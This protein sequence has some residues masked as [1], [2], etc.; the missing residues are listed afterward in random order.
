MFGYCYNGG[1][2]SST[3]ADGARDEAINE[4]P[5]SGSFCDY[6]PD[7]VNDAYNY[8]VFSREEDIELCGIGCDLNTVRRC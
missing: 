4:D 8:Y 6:F 5:N 1:G 2:D 7:P 3:E